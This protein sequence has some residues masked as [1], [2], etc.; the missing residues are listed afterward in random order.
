MKPD[1]PPRLARGLLSS[2]PAP[3]SAAERA[4][5]V[6]AVAELLASHEREDRLPPVSSELSS[7]LSARLGPGVEATDRDYAAAITAL[8][9]SYSELLRAIIPAALLAGDAPPRVLSLCTGY[10]AAVELVA[11]LEL[12]GRLSS[13]VAV[14]HDAAAL[15][16]NLDQLRTLPAG[17]GRARAIGADV[18]SES[19]M[20]ELVAREGPFDFGLVLRPPVTATAYADERL[21]GSRDWLSPRV[22]APV[23]LELLDLVERGHLP[24]LALILFAETEAA[25]LRRM[26]CAVGYDELAGRVRELAHG[27]DQAPWHTLWLA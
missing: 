9:T 12:C 17:V 27:L 3:T 18:R 7:W 26:L 20:V 11:L 23:V 14:E 24:P 2:A 8:A 19:A 22:D 21:R 10:D 16:C 1:T 4:S 5:W 6:T 25:H 13:Y 15:A